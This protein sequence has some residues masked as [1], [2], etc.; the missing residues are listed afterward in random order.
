MQELKLHKE[1]QRNHHKRTKAIE[2]IGGKRKP[3]HSKW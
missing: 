1:Q 2:K 3:V